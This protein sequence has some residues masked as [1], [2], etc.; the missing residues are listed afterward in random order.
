MITHLLPMLQ[1]SANGVNFEY[2]S[3]GS[4]GPVGTIVLLGVVVVMIAAMW[5]VFTKAGE[6]GWACLVPI[7]NVIV[8]L[9]ISGK[10]VWW[11]ILFIIPFVNF[12]I[13]LLVSLGLAK[14]FGKGGGFGVGLWLL[15]P[16]F[17]MIL[18]FGDAK[19][20]GQKS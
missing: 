9:K 7:Y 10:P 1:E 11:I 3:Q 16:I 12:I 8:Y 20:V 17:L 2:S 15:G 14:N 4:L 5:K 18:A 19:F 13:A 6:P